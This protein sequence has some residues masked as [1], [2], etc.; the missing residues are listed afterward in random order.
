M[1]LER[2]PCRA[3]APNAIVVLTVPRFHGHKGKH[4]MHDEKDVQTLE[5]SVRGLL[6]VAIPRAA[7]AFVVLL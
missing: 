4:I 3:V 5:S 6:E 1:S 2:L 7:K